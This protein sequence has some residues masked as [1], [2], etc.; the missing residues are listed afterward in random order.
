MHN[1]LLMHSKGWLPSCLSF[2]L[3]LILSPCA[4]LPPP[5][6]LERSNKKQ[7]DLLKTLADFKV[8]HSLAHDSDGANHT[9][10]PP[11]K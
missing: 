3:P 11:Y 8:F 4:T 10:A 5:Q 9:V 6:N 7:N 2:C 1:Q